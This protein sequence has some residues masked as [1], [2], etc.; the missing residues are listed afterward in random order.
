MPSHKQHNRLR[1][2]KT[3][4][5]FGFTPPTACDHCSAA[6]SSYHHGRSRKVFW[7]YPSRSSVC[8][9]IVRFPESCSPS[10]EIELKV[11]MNERVE[12]AERLSSWMRR[13]FA[14]SRLWNRMSLAQSPKFAVLLPNWAM[15]T[16][17]LGMRKTPPILLTLIP[18]WSQ[19]VLASLLT[20]GLSQTVVA[21][22]HSWVGSL[23]APM[24]FLRYCILFT[25]RDSGFSANHPLF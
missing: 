5:T 24:C 14:F 22:S 1:L 9:G 21:S 4:A 19:W 13:F 8:A 15:I 16:M 7:V 10:A 3:I 25:W 23:W 6:L 12:Q 11:A 20:L 18:Y 17:E 2:V